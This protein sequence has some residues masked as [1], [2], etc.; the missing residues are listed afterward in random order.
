MRRWHHEVSAEWL[1][2]RQQVITATDIAGLLPEYK[3]YVKAGSPEVPTPGF[4]ALWC[5]KHS[6]VHLDTSS[7][8][9]A[10]RGH[11]MEPYAINDLR[12]HLLKAWHWDDCVVV[13]GIM[14]CSP[15]G[16]DVPPAYGR[17]CMPH[18]DPRIVSASSV[19]EVKCYSPEQHMK[20]LVENHM[21]HKEL[22]QLAT[23]FAVMP[24]LDRG[25]LVWYC[26]GAPISMHVEEYCRDE[27]EEQIDT[28][29]A[30]AGVYGKCDRF[31]QEKLSVHKPGFQATYTEDE[32][33]KEHVAELA[34]DG[35][36][37]IK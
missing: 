10:A 29:I 22:L 2:A 4:S 12:R 15:D 5:R 27:L 20:S 33:Y 26:P 1:K 7:S 14:G 34:A 23:A 16:M 24:N 17:V 18:D 8:D 25:Y 3:R 13:N 9:A 30:I 37:M 28:A 6:D 36:F 31:W 32:I 35:K 19:Y 21:E 11:V